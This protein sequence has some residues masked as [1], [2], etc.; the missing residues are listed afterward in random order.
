MPPK[1]IKANVDDPV[2]QKIKSGIDQRKYELTN[3]RVEHDLFNNPMVE[4]ARKSIPEEQQKNWEKIGEQMYNSVDFVD[5]EG[6]TQTIPE[7][8]MEG[9]AYVVDS[10]TSGM[11]ISYLEDNEK[12]LLADVYGSTWYERFGYVE[13]DLTEIHTYPE[14]N[15][16]IIYPDT[17][18]K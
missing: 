6:K 11:H 7:S 1:R 4:K 18:N 2:Y 17:N 3:E 8:M 13:K 15:H 10:I 14:A 9:I 5:T 12:E 16:D